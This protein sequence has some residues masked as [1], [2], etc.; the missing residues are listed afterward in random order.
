MNKDL[1]PAAGDWK[2]KLLALDD[3]YR[4]E[5][6]QFI[7]F[8]EVRKLPLDFRSIIQ[9][10]GWLEDK[11]YA[12]NTI[13]KRI[14]A[15]KHRIKWIFDHSPEAVD[16]NRRVRLEEALRQIKG[17]KKAS[18]AVD[19]EK[20]LSSEEIKKLLEGCSEKLRLIIRLLATEGLRISEATGIRLDDIKDQGAFSTVRIRGKG[21]KEREIKIDNSFLKNL[22]D[23]FKGA[24]WLLETRNGRPY[25]RESLAKV[26]A[27]KGRQVLGKRISPHT[28]RHS[29]AYI[30][31]IEKRLPLETLSSYL[32]HYDVSITARMYL[33][34]RTFNV[35]ELPD[36]GDP[37]SIRKRKRPIFARK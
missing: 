1:Q 35:E 11:G 9:Y 12:P 29:F 27:E 4:F 32:G 33:P 26:I 8:L 3:N 34:R 24:T 21:R 37:D 25:R 2:E 6:F 16:L 30:Q 19:R 17:Y 20:C 28:F 7:G 23:H 15:I 18:A 31:R 22:R 10:V 36:F 14:A 13:N 5:T